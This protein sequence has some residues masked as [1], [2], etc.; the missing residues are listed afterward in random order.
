[1]EG[2]SSLRKAGKKS[3]NLVRFEKIYQ[4]CQH[5]FDFQRISQRD[6]T[7][8]WIDDYNSRLGLGNKFM[9]PQQMHFQPMKRGAGRVEPKQPFFDPGGEVD[10]DRT[11]I[12]HDKM[13]T[14]FRATIEA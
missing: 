5:R 8:N 6:V 9:H 1:L 12:S 13:R 14:F 3:S 11:P 7:R 4:A 2:T 10:A